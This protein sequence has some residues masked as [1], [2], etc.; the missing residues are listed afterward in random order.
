MIEQR[1]L[2]LIHAD[3]DGEL[4]AAAR[5]ELQQ[6][7]HADP[8]AQALHAQLAKMAGALGRM[9]P[10]APP[11]GLQ[12]QILQATRPSA[13]VLPFRE[14][15]QQFV[16]YAMALA[17]GMIIATVGI[18]FSGGSR[19]G[20][21]PDQLVGTIGGRDDAPAAPASKIA[22]QAPGLTGTVGLGEV[23]G[24]WQL[25]FDLSSEQPVTVTAAYADAAFRLGGYTQQ[26]PGVGSFS[27]TPGRIDFVNQGTQHLALFLEPGAG[28]RVR[29]SF[30]G[31]GTLPAEAVLDVPAQGQAR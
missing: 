17:A 16:R 25:V 23:D 31:Q 18:G 4:D 14:R 15:R 22:L 5:S 2:E 9:P 29:I 12:Q 21:D 30:A 19:L 24:R 8:E 28:G 3:L 1:I 13:K 7:L 10:V 6:A 11:A 27:A 20:L 26:D